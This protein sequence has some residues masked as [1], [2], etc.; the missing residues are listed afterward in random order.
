M[1]MEEWRRVNREV[2]ER[3]KQAGW[4]KDWSHKMAMVVTRPALIAEAPQPWEVQYDEWRAR[5]DA[6]LL[7]QI[8]SIQPILDEDPAKKQ[9]DTN[10]IKL[11]EA[12][13]AEMDEEQRER[14]LRAEEIAA[15]AREEAVVRVGDRITKADR[16]DNRRSL[17]R[18]LDANLYLLVKKNRQDHTWQFPQI[19]MPLDLSNEKKQLRQIATDGLTLSTGNNAHIYM[20][21]N[22]PAGF[23]S[24]PFPSATQKSLDTFGAKV[25]FYR[26]YYIK[27][28]INL[29]ARYTD[30]AWVTKEEL[31]DYIQDA[32][33]YNYLDGILF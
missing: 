17:R 7:A 27:G 14:A 30:H 4:K 5:Y 19:P 32:E 33:L 18:K 25:F 26:G 10:A 1:Q 21:G 28:D 6:P 2:N 22:A 16:E 23:Y 13:L 11:T 29:P 12:E 8:P 3:A 9:V 24:Y 20:V 31:K 15:A